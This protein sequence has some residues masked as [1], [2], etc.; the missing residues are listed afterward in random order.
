[1]RIV[2]IALFR[3]RYCVDKV[4]YEIGDIKM[5]AYLLK[6]ESAFRR[7]SSCFPAAFVMFSPLDPLKKKV[8][9]LASLRM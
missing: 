8:S 6:F 5:K 9:C 3:V 2:Q 4:K 1:M 7:Y